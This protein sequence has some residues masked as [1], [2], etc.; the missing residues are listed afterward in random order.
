MA[1]GFN[2]GIIGTR[3]LTT[4][5]TTGAATGIYSLNEAQVFKLA[6][7]WPQEIGQGQLLTT[8]IFTNSTTWTIPSGVSSVD[9]LVVAGGG[10][11]SSSGGAG[12]GAGGF[13]TG[14]SLSV[15]PAATYT[16]AVGA[17]GGAADGAGLSPQTVHF[18]LA[19]RCSSR[20]GP[21][22]MAK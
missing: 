9:Y 14:S 7:I 11:G 6:G 20:S 3:N 22:V 13:Q 4:G 21:A 18:S 17:G 1:K 8:Q 15:T 2:G 12:G 10:A 16:I 19:Y 5:G